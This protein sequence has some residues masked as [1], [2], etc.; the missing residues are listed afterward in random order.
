MN[1][2]IHRL[3][4][5]SI[6]LDGGT[7][8]RA[9]TDAPTIEEYALA[10]ERGDQ[11]PPLVVFH[12]GESHWLAS[13]FH[14]HSALCALGREDA[15]CE[16]ISGTRREA[17]LY[18]CGENFAHGMRRTNEDKR[19]VVRRLL[20]DEEW[21]LWSD[22]QVADRCKVS[23]RFVG[24]MREMLRPAVVPD[25]NKEA[26]RNGSGI[27]LATRNGT[28]YP[29]SPYNQHTYRQP[30]DDSPPKPRPTAGVRE[31]DEKPRYLAIRG[32]LDSVDRAMDALPSP[33]TAAVADPD[34]DLDQAE[35]HA[36][37][38][39]QFAGL[40]RGKAERAS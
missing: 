13:G 16:V 23:R 40:L 12:D 31:V 25:R 1:V 34:F 3:A 14:R 15:E 29:V 19:R 4:L 21:Q 32:T 9:I 17:V 20:E 35:R 10:M 28:T 39:K 11:F 7:Q 5:A 30:V 27:R 26:S 8:P 18:S 38:W 6:R 24:Q 2:A 37:W 36:R 22:E 33:E